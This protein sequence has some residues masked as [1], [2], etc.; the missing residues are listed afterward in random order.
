E[1]SLCEDPECANVL[2]SLGR[3]SFAKDDN[4]EAI[5]HCSK[6]MKLF[7]SKMLFDH[8]AVADNYEVFGNIYKKNGQNLLAFE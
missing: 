5:D 1:C 3:V 8:P 4:D 2:N 6:S 7:K